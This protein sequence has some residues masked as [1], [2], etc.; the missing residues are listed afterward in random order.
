MI[1]ARTLAA[2]LSTSVVACTGGGG[3]LA[4]GIDTAEPTAITNENADRSNEPARTFGERPDRSNE[5]A[6]SNS[7]GRSSPSASRLPDLD[8]SGKYACV[9]DGSGDKETYRPRIDDG[10]CVVNDMILERDGRLTA[11]KDNGATVLGGWSGKN[12]VIVTTGDGRRVCTK[13]DD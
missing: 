2:L 1:A 6:P 8:C 13:E 12:P 9:K 7:E 3:P 10:V 11:V 5:R 4:G